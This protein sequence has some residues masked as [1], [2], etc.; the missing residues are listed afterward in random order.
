MTTKIEGTFIF[1]S[2]FLQFIYFVLFFI[3]IRYHKSFF[4]FKHLDHFILLGIQSSLS[5]AQLRFL[6]KMY[7]YLWTILKLVQMKMNF[8]SDS[9][10]QDSSFLAPPPKINSQ[11]S[12]LSDNTTKENDCGGRKACDNCS[13]VELNWKLKKKMVE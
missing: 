5:K 4:F 10:F 8:L 11:G 6:L 13:L 1:F 2:F 9:H 3:G 7:P 12:L